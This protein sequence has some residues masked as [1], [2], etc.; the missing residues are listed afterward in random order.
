MFVEKTDFDD[1]ATCCKLQLSNELCTLRE[2]EENLES[3][4]NRVPVQQ[5]NNFPP[6]FKSPS[7][8]DETNSKTQSKDGNDLTEDMMSPMSKWNLKWKRKSLTESHSV[9]SIPNT[10]TSHN[11][12]VS[13]KRKLVRST[14]TPMN[15][16]L[17]YGH[18][19]NQ[20]ESMSHVSSI[21]NS[22]DSD[23]N[24]SPPLPPPPP[25]TNSR[26][27]SPRKIPKTRNKM[28]VAATPLRQVMSK[29]I[30]RAIA[31]HGIPGS[32]KTGIQPKKMFDSL[33]ESSI[34]SAMDL[35][36]SPV[37]RRSSQHSGSSIESIKS[38]RITKMTRKQSLTYSSSNSDIS[39]PELINE[40]SERSI[41]KTCSSIELSNTNLNLTPKIVGTS[42]KKAIS[43][44]TPDLIEFSPVRKT[45]SDVW[46]TPSEFPPQQKN[47]S[48]STTT[49]TTTVEVSNNIKN[50]E[51]E[52]EDEVFHPVVPSKIENLPSTGGGLWSIVSS[53][54][55]M[56]SF[57]KGSASS[58]DKETVGPE[59][60]LIKRCASFAGYL[61]RKNSSDDDCQPNKRRRTSSVS[62]NYF[63][64]NSGTDLDR[65]RR[66]IQGRL[67]I[68]R[69][70]FD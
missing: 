10:S 55:R 50:T 38:G 44:Q 70:R 8:P 31:V 16:L 46:Y 43:F 63:G 17:F 51:T 61:I 35:R 9:S 41:Y 1:I 15:G 21:N 34:S 40:Q 28:P 48:F 67:P 47:Y 27:D 33:N 57:G 58:D 69:M 62:N 26:P 5:L 65:K 6:Y 13:P 59:N 42:L 18:R 52:L 14:S 66:R 39:S 49:T 25:R 29:S 53:V 3:K 23:T 60:S 45:P 12:T 54:F 20:F 32:E 11:L 37:I 56:A 24:M 64:K 22:S 36:T 7:L 4:E 68:D 19:S 30:L 2:E